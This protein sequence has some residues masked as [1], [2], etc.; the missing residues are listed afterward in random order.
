MKSIAGD[1]FIEI[2]RG[3]AAYRENPLPFWDLDLYKWGKT[4]TNAIYTG[5]HSAW[6][7]QS[8]YQAGRH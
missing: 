7:K 8:T 4:C 2:R 3:N 5:L 1:S 6:K